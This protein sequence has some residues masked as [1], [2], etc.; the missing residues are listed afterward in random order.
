M[1]LQM[2]RAAQAGDSATVERLDQQF[3]PLWALFKAHGSL[4]VVHAICAELNLAHGALPRPL[5]PLQGDARE[6]LRAAM[7]GLS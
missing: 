3:Q 5:L 4:R 1:A 7:A 2:V 6:Q